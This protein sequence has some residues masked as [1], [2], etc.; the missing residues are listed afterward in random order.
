MPL[1]FE[2]LPC[3]HGTLARTAEQTSYFI[4]LSA[5]DG[6]KTERRSVSLGRD[7][8]RTAVAIFVS[9]PDG[10]RAIAAASDQSSAFPFCFWAAYFPRSG[11][12]EDVYGKR[13]DLFPPNGDERPCR[14]VRNTAVSVKGA[15]AWTE[16][17]QLSLFSRQLAYVLAQ[18]TDGAARATV[19]NE[20]TENGF[21]IWGWLDLSHFACHQLNGSFN[22][23]SALR[24]TVHWANQE[25]FEL[26]ENAEP[27]AFIAFR[28]TKVEAMRRWAA[29]GSGGNT[30]INFSTHEWD[31]IGDHQWR[32]RWALTDASDQWA[33]FECQ[34]VIQCAV[35][36]GLDHDCFSWGEIYE[37]EENAAN[38]WNDLANT[39]GSNGRN[40]PNVLAFETEKSELADS[41]SQVFAQ[42][43]RIFAPSLLQ[44]LLFRM[45][46]NP[47]SR[48]LASCAP[49]VLQ[50]ITSGPLQRVLGCAFQG[51]LDQADCNGGL[52]V[53][54]VGPPPSH[55]RLLVPPAA[56]VGVASAEAAELLNEGEETTTSPL[57]QAVLGHSRAMTALVSRLALSSNDPVLDLGRQGISLTRYFERFGGFGQTKAV[58]I[59]L[60][61]D[62]LALLARLLAVSL[63]QAF[64]RPGRFCLQEAC[65]PSQPLP[66]RL[67]FTAL[68]DF[69]FEPPARPEPP[70]PEGIVTNDVL[71]IAQHQLGVDLYPAFAFAPTHLNIADDPTR[72]LCFKQWE[73]LNNFDAPTYAIL[74]L[75]SKLADEGA[76]TVRPRSEAVR[77]AKEEEVAK[78]SGYTYWKREI[79]DAHVLPDN[80]PQKIDG[81]Q[82]A[83]VALP[84]ADSVSS[85]WNSAG[86]WE[87]KDM[88]VAARTEL[89]KILGDENS[90]LLQLDDKN[91]VQATKVTVTGDS[92]AYHIRGR[93]R[94][95]FEFTVKL[96]WKGFFD[97]EEVLGELEVQD[98]D[99]SD[100]DG[101]EIRPK[102]K[103]GEASKRA[104][105]ALK[106]GA[107]PAIKKAA[108]LLSQ[109]LLVR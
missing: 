56:P 50:E 84:K 40:S 1:R 35:G 93:P 49:E 11:L 37:G 39:K 109:R 81:D 10:A 86:T 43:S 19:R 65:R 32:W 38:A 64:P 73:Y 47:E 95:G 44:A 61:Q 15:E 21:E 99:S 12:L 36:G 92:S 42:V 13:C 24:K 76:S 9:R 83:Q 74:Q 4:L 102:P 104:A 108:E 88:G 94:L 54:F 57:A 103:A 41:G 53:A 18:I 80:R 91:K 33:L 78:K 107:R 48:I 14:G 66:V 34:W 72:V 85:S 31:G 3:R 100:L 105:A 16:K 90:F 82:P 79:D 20:D 67:L 26:N 6:M 52:A 7:M 77:M 51:G 68:V 97:G 23:L 60:V 71:M 45:P 69:P 8:G 96:S 55:H 87:E 101:F 59:E 62:H 5:C 2:D 70:G 25:V 75:R 27:I 98:L 30:R 63:E 22:A 58:K 29:G 17:D 28:R 46:G 89:E 106:S